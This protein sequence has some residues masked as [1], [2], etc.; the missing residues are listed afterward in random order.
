[1]EPRAKARDA[2]LPD[3]LLLPAFDAAHGAQKRRAGGAWE[4]GG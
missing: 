1:M 4:A 3:K 2:E